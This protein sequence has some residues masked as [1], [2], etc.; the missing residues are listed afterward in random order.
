[1]LK[2]TIIAF[3]KSLEGLTA[4]GFSPLWKTGWLSAEAVN[5]LIKKKPIISIIA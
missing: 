2:N 1:M 3:K 5:S 4:F